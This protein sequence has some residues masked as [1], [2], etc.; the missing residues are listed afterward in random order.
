V[1]A[2]MRA[3]AFFVASTRSGDVLTTVLCEI[4]EKQGA[5]RDFE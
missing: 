2:K 1:A 5:F 4:S 3:I